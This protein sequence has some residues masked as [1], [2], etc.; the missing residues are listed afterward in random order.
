M[1]TKSFTHDPK[2]YSKS[3]PLFIYD[4]A[5]N[6]QLVLSDDGIPYREGWLTEHL[7][8]Q[9]S[10][11]FA[12]MANNN[13]VSKIEI[14]DR[15]ITRDIDGNFAEFI[16]REIEDIDDA[17]GTFIYVF[18]EGGEYELYNE[19]LTGYTHSGV[20]IGTAL[21]AILAGTRWEV[22]Y[23]D[24]LGV[25]SVDLRYMTVKQ[26]LYELL[27]AFKGEEIGRAHV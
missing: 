13:M 24:D 10:Q 12:V 6:L 4:R 9:A 1:R 15:V 19:V 18:A 26:A 21:N 8:G 20:T 16:I 25:K 27:N 11:E 23:V 14:E 5:E 3:E 2:W 7:K 17:G 22:G